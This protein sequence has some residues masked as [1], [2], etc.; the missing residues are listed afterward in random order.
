MKVRQLQRSL[1]EHLAVLADDADIDLAFFGFVF[2][3]GCSAT[4]VWIIR[5]IEC[6]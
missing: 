6:V 5:F 2:A 1:G 3:N 4:A